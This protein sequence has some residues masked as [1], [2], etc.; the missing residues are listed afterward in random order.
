MTIIYLYYTGKSYFRLKLSEYFIK[1]CQ[2]KTPGSLTTMRKSA[3]LV[4]TLAFLFESI[5]LPGVSCRSAQQAAECVST[6][7]GECKLKLASD[8]NTLDVIERFVRLAS[9]TAEKL[10]P[11]YK[12]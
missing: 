7:I 3:K 12:F 1:T 2:I 6:I 11:M 10:L 9:I 8:I 4:Y 5:G